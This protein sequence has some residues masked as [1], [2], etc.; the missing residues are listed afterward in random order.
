MIQFL[1]HFLC[2]VFHHFKI[3]AEPGIVE[4]FGCHR[5]FY[6]PIVAMKIFTFT[7]VVNKIMCS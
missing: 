6:L 1:D 7:L 2:F 5:N 4:F 3:Y